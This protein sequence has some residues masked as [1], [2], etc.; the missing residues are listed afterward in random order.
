[1][2]YATYPIKFAHIA[3]TNY[4]P[5]FAPYNGCHLLL[6]HLIEDDPA[7]ASFYAQLDDGKPKIMDCSTFEMFKQGRPMFPPKKLIEMGNKVGADYIVMSDYPME[8]GYKTIKAADELIPQFKDAGFGTFF[9][10]Q[11]EIG[12]LE[13]YL[14]TIQWGI[15]NPSIDLIGISILGA[16]VALGL[17]ERSGAERN[18][19]Y[20]LQRFLARREIFNIM[21]A[22]QM[23]N[24]YS[25]EKRF[26]CLGMVDGPNEIDLLGIWDDCIYSWDSS[27]AVWAGLHG[28]AYDNSPTGLIDGKFEK[29]VDFAYPRGGDVV[30]AKQ[31]C[32]IINSMCKEWGCT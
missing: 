31:N 9:V 7:Y 12:N 11:S 30:T 3:P 14:A 18:D 20:K 24:T 8:P 21:D 10:P 29:E 2:T 1:M 19:A 25:V 15:D 26:H 4:L 27:S 23:L 17:D 22:R 5:D 6:A 13:D 32:H 28:I 16:P